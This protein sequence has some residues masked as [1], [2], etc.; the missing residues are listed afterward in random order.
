MPQQ[1]LI[2]SFPD[3]RAAQLIQH[4]DYQM[5]IFPSCTKVLVEVASPAVTQGPCDEI[6][7][8]MQVIGRLQTY[9]SGAGLGALGAVFCDLAALLALLVQHLGGS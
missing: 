8:I 5:Q 6:N 7:D 9:L 4:H 1:S 3:E 2:T